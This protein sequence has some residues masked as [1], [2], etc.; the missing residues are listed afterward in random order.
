MNHGRI[1]ESTDRILV[2]GASGFIGVKVVEILLEYG[3][4]NIRCLVR[5]SSRRQRLESVLRRTPWGRSVEV[6]TGDLTSRA[7]CSRIAE[8]VALTL[9]LAAGFDKSFSGAFMNSALATRNL[10]EALLERGR[11]IEPLTA[12]VHVE[13]GVPVVA[14]LVRGLVDGPRRAAAALSPPPRTRKTAT[15]PAITTTAMATFQPKDPLRLRFGLRY[16]ERIAA[17]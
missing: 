4:R 8:G 14:G 9:H 10:M 16:R 3:F 6:L 5:P 15:M 13:R 17:R 1:V 2:T 11:G 7:D 12:D